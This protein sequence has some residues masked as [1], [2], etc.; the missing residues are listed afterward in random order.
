MRKAGAALTPP[1]SPP[2]CRLVH[3][4]A[5]STAPPL[6]REASGPLAHAPGGR[7][8]W[9]PPE[10]AGS[11]LPQACAEVEAGSGSEPGSADKGA[12]RCVTVG[13]GRWS[14]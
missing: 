1:P 12:S 14:G 3:A 8:L 11:A 10:G 4:Q 5:G 13:G 9:K 7:R 2:T 6:H